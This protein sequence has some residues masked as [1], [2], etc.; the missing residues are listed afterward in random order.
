MTRVDL[1]RTVQAFQVLQRIP[2]VIPRILLTRVD[3]DRTV[4]T[5]YGLVQPFQFTQ[6]SP[7]LYHA[8]SSR[9]LMP[10]ARSQQ[11]TASASRPNATNT[12]ALLVPASS[13]PRLISSARSQQPTPPSTRF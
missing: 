12:P 4:M 5:G 11:A 8:C 7:L 1:D 13:Y 10:S 3:L 9:G 6:H 2:L